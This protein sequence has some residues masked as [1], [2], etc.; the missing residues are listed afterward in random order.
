MRDYYLHWLETDE[1]PG[2]GMDGVSFWHHVQGWWNIRRLPNVLFVH[3]AALKADMAGE[4]ARIAQFLDIKV[5]VEAWPR[6][7]E[8]CRFDYMRK[9]SEATEWLN[10]TW[11][12]GGKTFF[13]QGVN[14]RWRDV[15]TPAEIARCEEIA[16]DRLTPDCARWLTTGQLAG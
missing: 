15:L 2:W 8:H 6:I 5:D 16:A 3:F 4:I 10:A 12:D 11:K 13:N 7:L 9:A 14:G 1:L